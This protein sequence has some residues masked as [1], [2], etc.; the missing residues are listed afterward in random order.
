MRL[1]DELV[2]C[3]HD[4]LSTTSSK[5]TFP[6]RR[7]SSYRIPREL[8]QTVGVQVTLVPRKTRKITP[9]PGANLAAR[10]CDYRE[11]E[12]AK[13]CAYGIISTIISSEVRLMGACYL[14]IASYGIREGFG[15]RLE[16]SICQR[17]SVVYYYTRLSFRASET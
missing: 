8:S 7:G 1:A 10:F 5:R 11:S 9:P 17:K 14:L 2:G 12:N 16:P 4:L 6:S 3:A 13:R 15:K